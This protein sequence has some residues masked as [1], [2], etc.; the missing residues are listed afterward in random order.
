DKGKV[1]K[2]TSCKL[3]EVNNGKIQIADKNGGHETIMADYLVLAVGFK[4][5]NDLYFHAQ[6]QHQNVFL[7]GDAF[8]V[9]GFKNALLQ[10]EMLGH[11]IAA[12]FKN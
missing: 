9:K 2:R 11:T 7:I 6:G 4:P 8:E 12:R 3:I 1:Q 5:D 10:G